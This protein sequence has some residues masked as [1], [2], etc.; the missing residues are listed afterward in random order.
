MASLFHTWSINSRHYSTTSEPGSNEFSASLSYFGG[1]EPDLSPP[2]GF[3]QFP[4]ITTTFP[5]TFQNT[6]FYHV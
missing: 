2:R 5:L 3:R 4:L 1:N 6:C